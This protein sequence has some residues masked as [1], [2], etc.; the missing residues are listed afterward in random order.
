[1]AHAQVEGISVQ[2][3]WESRAVAGSRGIFSL[4]PWIKY[5]NQ[6]IMCSCENCD[7]ETWLQSGPP[8][9]PKGQWQYTKD[10]PFSNVNIAW[11]KDDFLSQPGVSQGMGLDSA[12]RVQCSGEVRAEMC[13]SPGDWSLLFGNIFIPLGCSSPSPHRPFQDNLVLIP[14]GSCDV[15]FSDKQTFHLTMVLSTSIFQQWKLHKPLPSDIFTCV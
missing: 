15:L 4:S 8:P 14:K 1:M 7:P 11:N 2:S 10:F 13:C 9:P 12:S 5:L 3:L 6:I